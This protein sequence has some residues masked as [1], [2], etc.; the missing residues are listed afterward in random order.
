MQVYRVLGSL[1][2]TVLIF[3]GLI[4][5]FVAEYLFL[6]LVGIVSVEPEDGLQIA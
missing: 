1:L 5:A 6:I 2:R 4:V 3:L